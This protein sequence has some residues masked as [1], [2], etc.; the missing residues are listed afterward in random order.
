MALYFGKQSVTMAD[1]IKKLETPIP[2]TSHPTC[3][4]PS[5]EIML[6]TASS[7]VLK[8]EAQVECR[9]SVELNS[10]FFFF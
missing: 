9:A 7:V 3:A 6:N 2:S 4:I 10:F 5:P 8:N 1:S